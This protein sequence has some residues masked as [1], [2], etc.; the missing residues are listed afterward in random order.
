MVLLQCRLNKSD[1]FVLGNIIVTPF[2]NVSSSERM[3]LDGLFAAGHLPDGSYFFAAY[4]DKGPRAVLKIGFV[5]DLGVYAK[6]VD[7]R[8]STEAVFFEP[9]TGFIGD[10]NELIKARRGSRR[11]VAEVWWFHS[12]PQADSEWHSFMETFAHTLGEQIFFAPIMPPTKVGHIDFSKP[13]GQDL[14]TMELPI[15]ATSPP[16]KVKRWWRLW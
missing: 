13:P 7:P 10:I 11:K 9:S 16:S 14:V 5:D 3:A 15:E 4:P 1:A 12:S 6:D 2:L 8:Q